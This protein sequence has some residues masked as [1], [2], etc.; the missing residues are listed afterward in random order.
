MVSGLQALRKMC[1]RQTKTP[2]HARKALSH[3]ASAL[4]LK[5]FD[6]LGMADFPLP[7]IV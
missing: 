6:C 2:V 3:C 4:A 5:V 7:C 1:W